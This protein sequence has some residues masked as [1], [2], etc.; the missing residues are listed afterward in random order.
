MIALKGVTMCMPHQKPAKQQTRQIRGENS[1]KK[2]IIADRAHFEHGDKDFIDK[3]KIKIPAPQK[4]K[5]FFDK[6]FS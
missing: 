5:G 2:H 3:R 4:E 1:D 6:L